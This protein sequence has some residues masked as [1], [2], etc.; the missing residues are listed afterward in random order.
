VAPPTFN[1]PGGAYDSAQPVTIS[2]TTAGASI[3]YT[4]DGST[5]TSSV[6]TVYVSPV[7]VSSSLTLKAIAYEAGMTDSLVTSAAYTIGGGGPPWYNSSW[8]SRKAIT[9]DHTKVSGS[10]NL[11]NFPVLISVTDANLKTVANGGSVGK[12]DGTD[13]LF[14]ASDGTTKLNHELES[15]SGTTGKAVAWVGIP[16][17]SPTTDTVIYVYYGNAAAADQQNKTAVWDSNYHAVIHLADNL[18]TTAVTDSTSSGNNGVASANSGTLDTVG[19]INGGFALNGANGISFL[20]IPT[21][22]SL[23]MEAWVN[24]SNTAAGYQN[25]MT[26]GGGTG[27]WMHNGKISLYTNGAHDGTTILS[28]GIWYHAVIVQNG[29]NFTYYLNGSVDATVSGPA[30]FTSNITASGADGGS[31][32]VGETFSGKLD[33]LRVSNIVRSADWILT[34]FRNQNSPATFYAVGPQE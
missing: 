10:S 8:T 14:T 28:T 13:I 12:A 6:G 7:A 16:T 25:V 33:E 21:G 30:L 27:W 2:S 11:T 29:V 34:E 4:I 23:T 15:Y 1:P 24:L 5:P 22:S 18:A 26:A 31:A 20:G 3:R 17:L 19:Q 9:I 32:G